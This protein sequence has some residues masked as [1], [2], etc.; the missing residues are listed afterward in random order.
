MGRTERKIITVYSDMI[1]HRLNC[2]WRSIRYV[3][4]IELR[5]QTQVTYVDLFHVCL[6]PLHFPSCI[7]SCCDSDVHMNAYLCQW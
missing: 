6:E 5:P 1:W 7:P 4:A 3:T 2:K